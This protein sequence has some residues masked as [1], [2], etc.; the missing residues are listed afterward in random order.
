MNEAINAIFNQLPQAMHKLNALLGE[1]TQLSTLYSSLLE[2]HGQQDP[3]LDGKYRF[4]LDS[5]S[6]PFPPLDQKVNKSGTGSGAG[7]VHV[8]NCKQVLQNVCA[9]H[10]LSRDHTCYFSYSFPN[11]VNLFPWGVVPANEQLTMLTD[12]LR[13]I[14]LELSQLFLNINLGLSL[15]FPR[16][17]DNEDCNLSLEVLNKL[18]ALS[19]LDYLGNSKVSAPHAL[20]YLFL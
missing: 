4:V 6:K 3:L 10:L 5:A 2:Q 1:L 12:K 14:F 18:L 16:T 17:E 11:T 13:T 9:H 8:V 20:I 15:M 7:Q 19:S